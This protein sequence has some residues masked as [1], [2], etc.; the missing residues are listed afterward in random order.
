MQKLELIDY[1]ISINIYRA[2]NLIPLDKALGSVDAYVIANFSGNKVKSSIIRSSNP[3]WNEQILIGTGIPTKSKYIYLEVR[4]RNR[5]SGDDI[6][7]I[8]KIPFIDL[9]E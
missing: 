9:K 8:I 6:I 7:G 3:V 4:N 1:G 2:E 5:L